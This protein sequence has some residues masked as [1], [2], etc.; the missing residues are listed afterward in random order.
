MWRF[1]TYLP[2]QGEPPR[3]LRNCAIVNQ[4]CHIL[5]AIGTKLFALVEQNG[6]L[7]TLWKY[8]LG[9]NVPGSPAMGA[10]GRIRIHSSDGLLH[11][12]SESGEQVWAPVS[13][14][15]P[16]GWASPVVDAESNT[17]ICCYT[18]GLIKVDS[19]GSRT[20]TPYFY[21]RQK[22]DC[23]GVI[24]D[25]VLYVGAEDAFIYAIELQGNKGKNLWEPAEGRGKTQW[26]INS[27]PA[28]A[29][30]L[31]LVVAGRDEY[32]Y[33]FSLDGS[34]LWKLH[35]RGQILASPVIDAK[36]NIYV[37]VSLLK[38]GE[39]GQGKLVCV[40]GQSH[41]VRWEYKA[42]GPVESTP[43]IGSDGI[44]YFGDNAGTIHAVRSDGQAAWSQ[45]VNSAVRS[46][47]TLAGPKRLLFGLDDGCLVALV[48]SSN[49]LSGGWPK[50]MGTLTQSG[51]SPI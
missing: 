40:D 41:R 51:C 8:S 39:R 1:P 43:V 28:L 30:D 25:H 18:G 15:E 21:S 24:H 4:Q 42:A 38:L 31:S 48:C 29:T 20:S 36:G 9:G 45:N 6:N 44:V 12:V 3:A 13:V 33:A 2:G 14:G 11:C 5:A 47:G 26:F 37:G 49:D 19:R 7:E 35:I 27:A 10:D 17:W 46:S 22:F 34:Q 16:L 23:T 50:Y 32:L